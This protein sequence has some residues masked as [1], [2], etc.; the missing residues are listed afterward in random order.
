[1][2]PGTTALVA[3][4]LA[5]C[6]TAT[7]APESA[8]PSSA[9]MSAAPSAAVEPYAGAQATIPVADGPRGVAFADGSIWVA[10]TIGGVV[11]RVNP[12][13]NQIVAEVDVG[14][15]P[16]TLVTVG[17]ELWVSVLND[18]PP[19]DD[20]IVQ[21][22]TA[23]DRPGDR[24]Q[25]PVHHNVAVGGGLIWVQDLDG[26]LRAADPDVTS[27]ADAVAVGFGPVTLAANDAAVYGVRSGGTVW[28]WP[29]GGGDLLEADLDV[30]VPG[31]SRIAA[32]ADGV[33][34]AIPGAVVALDPDSLEVVAEVS[35]PGMTLVNDLYLTD[36][37]VWLSANVFSEDLALAGGSVLRLDPATLE[38]L[39]TRPLGPESSG[40]VV[41]EGSVWA[42][43]QA[44]HVLAR[45]PLTAP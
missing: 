3:L 19:S 38:V 21:I 13:T 42:V 20:E 30:T 35:L 6:G 18:D 14:A 37:D 7:T 25:V 8:M 29:T 31:R 23:A 39:E 22:D 44:E 28:R 10:S 11:Q 5:G 40:V 34:V 32:T 12:G 4:A 43:D 26:Q 16:V 36:A 15:R 2:R 9:P 27:V 17:D 24:V 33:W 45:F 1:M 41:A